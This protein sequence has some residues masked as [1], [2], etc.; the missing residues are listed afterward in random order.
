MAFFA[1]AGVDGP[2]VR[3]RSA[4]RL[5][6]AMMAHP[7]LVAGEG[8]ACT[9]LMREMSGRVAVKTGAEAVFVAILR[10]KG[11]GGAIKIEDGTT[12]ASECT[13]VSILVK[14]G[15]L[16]PASP[17]AR[18]RRFAPLLNRR[19]LNVGEI[20]PAEHAFD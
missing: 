13:I 18:K 4:A 7:D 15:V 12:R 6:S 16:D 5:V 3:E 20:R 9:E 19:N 2:S 1:N 10:D 8:R 11:L 17:A 14:L